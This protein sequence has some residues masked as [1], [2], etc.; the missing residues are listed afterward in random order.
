MEK[1]RHASPPDYFK[2]ILWSYDFS[3]L[4]VEN[5][6]HTII[7]ATINYGKWRHWQWVANTY[8]KDVVAA[9]IADTPETALRRPALLLATLLFGVTTTNHAPRGAH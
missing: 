5:D 7:L 6:K 2:P 9:I 1:K 4:D 3:A 8:G